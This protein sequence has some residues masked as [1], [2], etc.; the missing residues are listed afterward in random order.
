MTEC[1]LFTVIWETATVD[2]YFSW[3]INLMCFFHL[4]KPR[5][6]DVQTLGFGWTRREMRLWTRLTRSFLV[7]LLKKSKISWKTSIP[8]F[9]VRRKRISRITN[10]PKEKHSFPKW[11][12]FLNNSRY[13]T[14]FFRT[15]GSFKDFRALLLSSAGDDRIQHIFCFYLG[16]PLH[17]FF[18]QV[19]RFLAVVCK[20][21]R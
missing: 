12:M 1:A 6:G 14:S 8:T 4:Q 15:W 21:Q 9:Q 10:Q 17:S 7:V 18:I 19:S 20:G 2:T 5:S 16:V 13:S 11:C 3:K